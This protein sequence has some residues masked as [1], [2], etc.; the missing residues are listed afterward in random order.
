MSIPGAEKKKIV[1]DFVKNAITESNMDET[2]KNDLNSLVD[3][4]IETIVAAQN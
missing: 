1:S 4:T 2:L 3:N